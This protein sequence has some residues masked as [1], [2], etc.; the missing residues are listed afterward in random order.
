MSAPSVATRRRSP[1]AQLLLTES[2]LALREPVTVVVGLALPLVLLLVFAAIPKFHE[3]QAALGGLTTLDVYV[4]ILITFILAVIA[5]TLMPPRLAT[6]RDQGV[7]R[8]MA[9]TPVHPSRLLAAQLVINLATAAAGIILMLIVSTAAFDV[10]P[11]QSPAGF[12]LAVVLTAASLFAIGL[13][14]TAVARSSQMASAFGAMF[15]FP[16]MFFA[17]LWVPRP[18]MPSALRGVSDYTPLGASVQ[19]MQSAMQGAFSPAR[20]LLVLAAYGIVFAALAVRQ[21]RWE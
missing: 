6:Y 17:G 7:L 4:P 3:H 19:A 18:L 5:L 14:I 8:R 2:R 15:F 12:V 16:L 1:F 21:F 13:W 20:A 11:P 10:R 9:T